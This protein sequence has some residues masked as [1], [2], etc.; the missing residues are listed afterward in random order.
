MRLVNSFL[1][2]SLRSRTQTRRRRLSEKPIRLMIGYAPGGSAEAG[3]RPLAKALEPLLG[4]PLVFDYR[5]Q[6]G[7]RGDGG[8]RAG[9]GGRLHALLL[10]QRPAHRRA[11]PQ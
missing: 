5:R 4:Q 6:C 2:C 8:D 11:A 3:A 7:R 1:R 9:A 10:R